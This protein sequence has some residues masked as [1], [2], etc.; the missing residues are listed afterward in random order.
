[1]NQLETQ[2]LP[3]ARDSARF[4]VGWAEMTGRRPCQEDALLLCGQYGGAADVDLYGVF[5]GHAGQMAA[6]FC[7]KLFPTL[8]EQHLPQ[9]GDDPVEAMRE[10]FAEINDHFRVEVAK[11]TDPFAKNCGSTALVAMVRARHLFVANLGDTRGVLSRNGRALRVSVDHK[12]MTEEHRINALGG[13]VTGGANDIRRVNGN[14]AVARSVGDYYMEPFINA[15]PYVDEYVLQPD[16]ELLVLACDGAWDVL[17]DQHVIDLARSEPDPFRAAAKIRDFA[18]LNDSDDN[19]S[20]VV[21]KL[22]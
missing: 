9:C 17:D 7:T 10:T 6:R 13:W 12:P 2:K 8:L 4:Q 14:L 22:K 19:I 1:L 16:D 18:Y 21:I 15:E 20:V 5:D 3:A 11:L